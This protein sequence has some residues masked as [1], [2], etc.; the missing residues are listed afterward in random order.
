MARINSINSLIK[1]IAILL[2]KFYQR[3][4][5]FFIGSH[6]CRYTPSCSNYM[7]EAIEKKGILKGVFLGFSRILRCN[8]LNK[9]TGFDPVE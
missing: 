7:I 4:L 3:F 9:K 5:T 6:H 2:V 1:N 8:P